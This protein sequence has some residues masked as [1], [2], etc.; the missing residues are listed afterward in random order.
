MSK[1][2][3][4]VTKNDIRMGRPFRSQVCPVARAIRLH[5]IAQGVFVH[6]LCVSSLAA[7]FYT[8]HVR[9]VVNLPRSVYRFVTRYDAGKSVKPF[10]FIV[11]M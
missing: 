10:N 7:V 2:K 11:E 3:I 1:I 4:S 8:D 6:D 5:F 9:H